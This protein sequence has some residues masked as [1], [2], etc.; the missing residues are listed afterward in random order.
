VNAALVAL[1]LCQSPVPTCVE[2][3]TYDTRSECLMQ[4]QAVRLQEKGA[5]LACRSRELLTDGPFAVARV[6][7]EGDR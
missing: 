7:G 5:R 2:L 4:A 1:I 3:A 6:Q